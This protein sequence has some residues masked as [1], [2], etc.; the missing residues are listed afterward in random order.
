M[1]KPEN[2][3]CSL[4]IDEFKCKP[5]YSRSW[6]NQTKSL[7]AHLIG[8][9]LRKFMCL[10][11]RRPCGAGTFPRAFRGRLCPKWL[12]SRDTLINGKKTNFRGRSACYPMQRW[13][14][15][16]FVNGIFSLKSMRIFLF[17]VDKNS[18]ESSR[19]SNVGIHSK[20]LVDIAR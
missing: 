7:K 14:N 1:G 6:A 4:A 5:N 20:E 10:D 16:V 8:N 9:S 15:I 17:S 19:I 3:L 12:N 2:L 13:K 18:N 11:L